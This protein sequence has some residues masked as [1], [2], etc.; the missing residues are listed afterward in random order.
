MYLENIYN[1]LALVSRANVQNSLSCDY[2][3][4]LEM[5]KFLAEQAAS[6]QDSGELYNVTI[7]ITE[8]ELLKKLRNK[9]RVSFYF[10]VRSLFNFYDMDEDKADNLTYQIEYYTNQL[11]NLINKLK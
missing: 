3:H 9:T 7:C 11:F 2:V 1:G 5:I 4:V 8:K 6:E 10:D